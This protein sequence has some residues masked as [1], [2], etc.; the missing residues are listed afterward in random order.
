MSTAT[1]PA[2]GRLCIDWGALQRADIIVST[3]AHPISRVIRWA[4]ES[5]ISHAMLYV[6]NGEVIEAI[7]DDRERPSAG[8]VVK[9]P[10]TVA[11]ADATAAVAL[12]RKGMT[13]ANADAVIRFAWKQWILDRKYDYNATLLGGASRAPRTVFV[14]AIL[15]MVG[16]DGTCAEARKGKLSLPDRFS[17]SELIF[18][19][20]QSANMP[21][22]SQF[23]PGSSSPQDLVNAWSFGLLEYVGD[24][25]W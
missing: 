15:D 1:M 11:L 10:L 9:R 4:T 19:S 17:C 22:I 2:E 23:E 13:P 21:I 3:T 20:F 24:L 18:E 8:G 16:G 6:G 5:C 25:V 7:G 14:C 12:R